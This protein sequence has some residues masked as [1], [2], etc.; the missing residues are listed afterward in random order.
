[1][2]TG[3]G[4]II[5]LRLIVAGVLFAS[6]ASLVWLS[7]HIM[8]L[9]LNGREPPLWM[10]AWFDKEALKRVKPRN[11]YIGKIVAW[12]LGVRLFFSE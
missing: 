2:L 7:S 11:V 8:H 12:S 4:P 9:T 5:N 10:L 3:W 1:M 6:L